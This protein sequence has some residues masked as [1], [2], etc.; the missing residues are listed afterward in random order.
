MVLGG[1]DC[2][3]SQNMMHRCI[4][5]F[6]Y[7]AEL[8]HYR[9]LRTRFLFSYVCT[10]GHALYISRVHTVA[11]Y[12]ATYLQSLYIYTVAIINYTVAV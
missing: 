7:V 1:R 10:S 6:V 9:T 5:R 11:T 2:M 8:H 4:H 3:A 12:V